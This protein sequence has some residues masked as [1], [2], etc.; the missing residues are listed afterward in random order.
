[1]YANAKSYLP[2]IFNKERQCVCLPFLIGGC[3]F[4]SSDGTCMLCLVCSHSVFLYI[5]I[6]FS[7]CFCT[8]LIPAFHAIRFNVYYLVCFYFALFLYTSHSRSI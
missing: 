3:A 8:C 1:M 7:P 5:S 2:L 6:L 4:Y